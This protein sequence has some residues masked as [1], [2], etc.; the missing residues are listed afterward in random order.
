[1][2]SPPLTQRCPEKRKADDCADAPCKKMTFNPFMTKI[3]F[4]RYL[5]TVHA[6][7]DMYGTFRGKSIRALYDEAAEMDYVNPIYKCT[8][9]AV[10][11][12]DIPPWANTLTMDAMHEQFKDAP[13]KVY[14]KFQ[15]DDSDPHACDV[16]T[17][18]T[19][20]V[21]NPERLHLTNMLLFFH[22][23]IMPFFHKNA[24]DA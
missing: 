24:V 16:V 14:F 15:Y 9:V 20:L 7:D 18:L 23:Q 1:M 8:A 22:D 10:V 21:D 4:A 5:L 11:E 19:C 3:K 13:Y 2:A 6:D 17:K 12:T